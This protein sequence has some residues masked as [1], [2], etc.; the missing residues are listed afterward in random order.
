MKGTFEEHEG[1]KIFF[2]TLHPFMMIMM[3][4]VVLSCKKIRG[5]QHHKKPRNLNKDA[6]CLLFPVSSFL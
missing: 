6:S 4:I 1:H 2:Q 5:A 3:K